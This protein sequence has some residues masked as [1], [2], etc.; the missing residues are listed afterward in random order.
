MADYKLGSLN[1]NQLIELLNR[2]DEQLH[3][4]DEQLSMQDELIAKLKASNTG[5]SLFLP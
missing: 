5:A 2:K 1:K 4:K 3:R